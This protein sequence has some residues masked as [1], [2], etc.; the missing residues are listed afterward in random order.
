MDELMCQMFHAHDDGFIEVEVP[1][2]ETGNDF[3]I[4]SGL[5]DDHVFDSLQLRY[6]QTTIPTAEFKSL[7]ATPA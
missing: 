2:F 4:I 3:S 7:R 5:L 1:T 6:W